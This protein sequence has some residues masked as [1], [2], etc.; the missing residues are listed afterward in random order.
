ME[1]R[2]YTVVE[3][4]TEGA[5]NVNLIEIAWDTAAWNSRNSFERSKFSRQPNLM[6]S[7]NVGGGRSKQWSIEW[8][9]GYAISS[10]QQKPAETIRATMTIVAIPERSTR[11]IAR[12]R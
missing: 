9:I 4:A 5:I 10:D 6:G 11:D 7:G 12:G 8:K 3:T 1:I 2:W